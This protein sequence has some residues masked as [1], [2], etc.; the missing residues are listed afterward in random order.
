MNCT[1]SPP[2]VYCMQTDFER[3]S[4]R[5][6]TNRDDTEI[7][8]QCQDEVDDSDEDDNSNEKQK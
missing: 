8:D 6:Y 4:R 7:E 5:R 3:C 1:P 2:T